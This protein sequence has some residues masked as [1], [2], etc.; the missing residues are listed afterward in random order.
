MHT[1]KDNNSVKRFRLSKS[2]NDIHCINNN[3][4]ELP[5]ISKLN[6]IKSLNIDITNFDEDR[7][8]KLR[9]A[10]KFF[11]GDKAN[12]KLNIIENGEIKPCGGIYLTDKILNV[13][14]EISSNENVKLN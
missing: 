5:K 12:V 7:K 4:L 11:A 3:Y 10:I 2:Q 14:I 1:C 6:T 8:S 9:G 13:F